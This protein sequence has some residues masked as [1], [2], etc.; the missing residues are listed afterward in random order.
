MRA[1]FYDFKFPYHPSPIPTTELVLAHTRRIDT[2]G[3]IIHAMASGSYDGII[4]PRRRR[5]KNAA[6]GEVY[7]AGLIIA[8]ARKGRASKITYM[9]CIQPGPGPQIPVAA[10]RLFNDFFISDQIENIYKFLLQG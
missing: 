2:D 1:A 8:P 4:K 9:I 6:S 10:Q 3:V 5:K 7:C